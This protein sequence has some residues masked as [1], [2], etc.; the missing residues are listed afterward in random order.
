MAT[1]GDLAEKYELRNHS[2]TD[3]ARRNFVFDIARLERF[4]VSPAMNGL[5]L[6]V[7]NEP[8]LWSPPRTQRTTRDGDFRLHGGWML[9]G[10]LLW[11]GG[12]YPANTR[13]LTGEY[14][15]HW[16]EYSDQPGAGGNFRYLAVETRPTNL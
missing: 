12:G 1:V 8:T 16:T 14:E 7:T 6:I 15:L 11:G 13:H 10:T 2:A 3:L 4:A 9:S 5:A